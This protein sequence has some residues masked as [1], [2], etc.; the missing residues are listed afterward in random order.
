MR[1]TMAFR[2]S[3]V[4]AGATDQDIM[5]NREN[6]FTTHPPPIFVLDLAIIEH[7]SLVQLYTTAMYSSGEWYLIW[8][9]IFPA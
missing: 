6:T 2:A 7:C 4:D 3:P 8:M 9:K 5:H 1:L